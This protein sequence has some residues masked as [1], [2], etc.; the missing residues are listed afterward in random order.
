MQI[1]AIAQN[2]N[3]LFRN[4][5]L[6]VSPE[7]TP[8]PDT[9]HAFVVPTKGGQGISPELRLYMMGRTLARL[10]HPSVQHIASCCLLARVY[11]PVASPMPLETVPMKAW[12]PDCGYG[13]QEYLLQIKLVVSPLMPQRYYVARVSGKTRSSFEDLGSI[14]SDL[15]PAFLDGVHSIGPDPHEFYNTLRRYTSIEAFVKLPDTE[16]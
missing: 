12:K 10:N 14:A 13:R 5:Q 3:R 11:L 4:A 8:T 6:M 7:V 2:T 1:P 15:L 16:R 9:L